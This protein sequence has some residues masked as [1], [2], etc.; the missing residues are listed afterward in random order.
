MSEQRGKPIL[1]WLVWTALVFAGGFFVGNVSPPAKRLLEEGLGLHLHA[2]ESDVADEPRV[3]TT[4]DEVQSLVA[5]VGN[6]VSR[7]NTRIDE[8]EAT[9]KENRVA[10]SILETRGESPESDVML[11]LFHEAERLERAL[12]EARATRAE[13]IDSEA[14]LRRIAQA[15]TEARGAGLADDE[16]LLDTRALFARL[17][18]LGL[19]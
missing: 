15:S 12:E 11:H 6:Y 10:Q 3:M 1:G 16:L 17:E 19:Q 8:L 2:A 7:I 4:R 18:M 13:A 5:R 14:E 9:L